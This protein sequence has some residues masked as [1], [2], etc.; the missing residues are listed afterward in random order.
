MAR[1]I[2]SGRWQNRSDVVCPVTR[3]HGNGLTGETMKLV[4]AV[5]RPMKLDNVC[6]ALE[7]LGIA[8]LT[9]M[10]VRG[11]GRVPRRGEA[12]LGGQYAAN[13]QARLKIEV[14]VP[15]DMVE[16]VV[17]AIITAAQ[18]GRV[19]DGKIFVLDLGDIVRIRTRETG[20]NAL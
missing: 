2:W 14:A 5:I 15:E 10:E 20:A 1:R 4:T 18:T 12:N 6:E 16:K 19:G 17:D 7:H 3:A 13:F 8:G 9:V 11:F